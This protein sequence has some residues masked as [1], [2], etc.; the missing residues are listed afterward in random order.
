MP[1]ELDLSPFPSPASSTRPSQAAAASLPG[2]L[3]TT[4]AG[5]GGEIQTG[6]CG[7]P[8]AVALTANGEILVAG[9]SVP[10]G[11]SQAL[12]TLAC[13][14]SGGL[15]VHVAD[16]QSTF[17]SSGIA[18]AT[19]NVGQ[20][21]TLPPVAFEDADPLAWHTAA[22]DWGDGTSDDAMVDETA[23]TA[24]DSF[25][26]SGTLTDSHAFSDAGTYTGTVT[27]TDDSG[28]SISEQFSVTVLPATVA[29][30]DFAPSTDGTA[31]DVSYT[32][33]DS[34]DSQAAPFTIS[35]YSSADAATPDT[36]L[37]SYAVSNSADLTASAAGQ[38][39]TVAT[40]PTAADVAGNYSLL[41]LADADP[42]PIPF[43]GGIFAAGTTVYV[44]ATGAADSVTIGTSSIEFN[45]RPS[46]TLPSGAATIEVRTAGPGDSVTKGQGTL[47]VTI[48]GGAGSDA[49]TNLALDAFTVDTSGDFSVTYTVSGA[50]AV[51]FTIGV[52]GSPG[53][54][55]YQPV[56]L[57]QTYPVSDPSLLA[58]G[59]EGQAET[60]TVTFAAYLGQLDANCYLLADLDVYNSV[61]ETSK[62]DNVSTLPLCGVFQTGDGSVYAF[63]PVTAADAVNEDLVTQ[64]QTTGTVT[65][66]VNGVNYTYSFRFRPGDRH[67]PG[68]TAGLSSSAVLRE[69]G[70][71]ASFLLWK[72]RPDPIFPCGTIQ[73]RSFHRAS[74]CADT[75][76]A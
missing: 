17:D 51:P 42:N 57:L 12:A 60:Y 56:E 8:T 43:D 27:L 45:Q 36:L 30:T 71:R 34:V 31:L 14:T 21:Y 38:S 32:I 66:G 75:G 63:A 10:T 19:V 4:F 67:A 28:A 62:T 18:P 55:S 47:P 41:A 40:T 73:N 35:I 59:S 61:R 53:G 9:S 13:F 52:Y 65:V 23:G 24:S 6:I 72:M 33:T 76:S 25:A 5:S 7:D 74:G 1:E 16:V 46:Y 37:W 54:S 64:N 69:G 29:L 50:D 68:A 22:V 44:F 49:S 20:T 26:Y 58:V 70:D 3:D 11:S 2:Q 15:G 39:H 48:Y